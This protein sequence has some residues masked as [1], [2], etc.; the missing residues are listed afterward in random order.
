[1]QTI[2]ASIP[3]LFYIPFIIMFIILVHYHQKFKIIDLTIK[4]IPVYTTS[5]QRKTLLFLVVT[6]V[7]ILMVLL[8]SSLILPFSDVENAM[9]AGI[10]AFWS[11]INPYT[12]DVVPHIL[13]SPS[14]S[15]KT[16][17]GSYNYGPLD[18]LV[19]SIGFYMFS[20][21]LG[22]SWWIVGFN[23]ILIFIIYFIFHHTFPNISSSIKYPI[24]MLP[25]AFFLPDNAVL[26][27][28]FLALA[29]WCYINF[30]KYKHMTVVILLTLGVLTKLFIVFVLAGYFVYVF[31]SEII[32]WVQYTILGSVLSFI[33]MYPF[34]ILAVIDSAFF[35]HS[36]LDT[37]TQFATIQGGLPVLLEPLGLGMF[38]FYLA[39]ILI[40]IFLIFVWYYSKDINYQ[41]I[42]LTLLSLLILPSSVYAFMIIPVYFMLITYCSY[43]QSWQESIS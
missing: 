1:M 22:D 41:F 14:G 20:W 37:R 9:T 15:T 34:N 35:F 39:G 8:I 13:I 29:G 32:L 4:Q 19:Y 25:M 31:K 40:V 26:M 6:I 12:E 36:D 2:P 38:Y 43:Y 17:L 16:V 42:I 21:L 33:I 3:Q 10:K 30:Q 23:L 28:V 27:C 7:F 5:Y 18:L 24:F 11:G